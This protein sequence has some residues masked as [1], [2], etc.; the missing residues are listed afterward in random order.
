M[1][2]KTISHFWLMRRQFARYFIV[3]FSGVFLDVGTLFLMKEYLHLRPVAAV[4]INGFFLL[5][6]IFFLNKHWTFK[7][8]GATRAQALRFLVLAGFN[9]FVSIGWMFIFNEKLGINYLLA[10]VLNIALSVAWN[11]LLY[12]YWVYKREESAV[13]PPSVGQSVDRV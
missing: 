8:A 10:R 4:V 12:K 5:N 11:F 3:G 13:F 7:S 2:K 6:Y 9:Y 1:I